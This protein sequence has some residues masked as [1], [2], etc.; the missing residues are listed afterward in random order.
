MKYAIVDVE[1][2]GLRPGRN[3][4]TE[5]GIVLFDGREILETFTSLFNPEQ[6]LPA[7]ISEMTGITQEMLEDAP[8][9]YEEAGRIAELTENA[10]FV[11][12]NVRFDYSFVVEEFKRLG[13]SYRRQKL[14]TLQLMR[15]HFPGLPSY[16]LGRLIHHFDIPVK[17]RH[18]ALD[19]ALATTQ[20]L[21]RILQ[22][23]RETEGAFLRNCNRNSMLPEH[24][25]ADYLDQLPEAC[26]VYY[27]TDAEGQ[28]LYVGKS[29]NIRKRIMQHFNQKT[30]KAA[31][32]QSQVYELHWELTGNELMALLLE[33]KEI[34]RLSPPFNRAQR[35]KTYAKAV[36]LYENAQGYLC[37]QIVRAELQREN[38]SSFQNLPWK[39]ILAE[40]EHIIAEFPGNGQAKRF[41]RHLA[42]E[43]DLCSRLCGLE[44]GVGPCFA[45][46]L[47]RCAGAC[48]GKEDPG[49]YNQRLRQALEQFCLEQNKARFVL[50]E[51]GKQSDERCLILVEAGF[52]RGYAYLHKDELDEA[53]RHPEE[54][55]TPLPLHPENR[56]ILFRYLQK[57]GKT[58][59]PVG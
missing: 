45:H 24:W 38:G 14:C 8:Y 51:E 10:I 53:L 13:Y 29:L 54:Q 41:L 50:I 31:R 26:G 37:L 1:T 21:Q 35:R 43:H 17:N 16:S 39:K 57:S 27:M 32:M 55:I 36:H 33:S 56:S 3:R 6:R 9:F 30:A 18:R 52:P 59:Y 25:N 7:G 49:S 47:K 19:D 11:G 28:V 4:I 44:K 48:C 34:K 2:T 40:K 20:L 12:H 58:L 22:K 23:E 46:Q 42:A 5:I 15:K